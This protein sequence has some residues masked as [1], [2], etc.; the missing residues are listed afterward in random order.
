VAK[1]TKTLK[2]PKR[3]AGYKVSKRTRKNVGSLVGLLATPEAKALMG[4]AVAAL[5]GAIA[6]KREERH[7]LPAKRAGK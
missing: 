3:V 5:A 6:G 1:K 4:S 7:G 2:M